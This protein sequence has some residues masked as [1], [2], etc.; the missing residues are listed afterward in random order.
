MRCWEAPRRGI[1]TSECA[2]SRRASRSCS[3]RAVR[4]QSLASSTDMPSPSSL[5]RMSPTPPASTSILNARGVSVDRVLDELLGDARRALDHLAGR[6][7][8]GEVVGESM[9]DAHRAYGSMSR[10]R[11][12]TAPKNARTRRT[13][14]GEASRSPTIASCPANT[15]AKCPLG[16]VVAHRGIAELWRRS[17]LH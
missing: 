11:S 5:T 9:D 17:R 15:I 8:V 3:S 7:L 4:W 2:T 14:Q 12:A 6:D 10:V 1:R 16:D 13:R